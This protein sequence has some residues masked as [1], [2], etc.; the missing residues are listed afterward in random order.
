MEQ[1][2]IITDYRPFKTL[3]IDGGGIKG[4]YSSTIL[5]H[6]EQRFGQCS[7]YFDMICG[8]STGG[9]IALA[10]A[11]GKPASEIS[12]IYE[13][14]GR[15]IFPPSILPGWRSL[16]QAIWGGKYSDKPLKGVLE[17]FFGTHTVADLQNLVCI[18][19]YSITDARPWVFKRDHGLLDRDNGA[20]LVDV[21]LATSAAPTFFPLCEIPH[22]NYKQFIDGGVW[23]NNPAL[24]GIIEALTYFVGKDK[25]F[26][27]VEVLSVS[28][29]NNTAGRSPGLARR[30]SFLRWGAELFEPSL[31]GQS[32][33][34]DY[35]LQKLCE[36]NDIK[37]KYIR[38]PSEQ[39]SA[40][41]QQLVKLDGANKKALRFIKGK[42]ND[43]GTIAKKDAAVCAFFNNKKL[44]K[45]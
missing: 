1:N 27:A 8:T 24:V 21:A 11:L 2:T 18:P 37:V 36:M 15:K 35:F 4:L 33:F 38:I 26:N 7:E 29:L 40:E 9:L 42:G 32:A 12:A 34:T 44:F 3:T 16:C 45:L 30:R 25:P 10:L 39:I 43:R 23:A 31:I 22:Y 41:Q 17:E 13:K 6:L 20:K 28:S 19:S 14:Q 5:E